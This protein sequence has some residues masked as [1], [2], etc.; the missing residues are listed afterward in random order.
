M[1][2]SAR[3]AI[4]AQLG[5]GERNDS[6]SSEYRIILPPLPTGPT[7]LNTVFLHADV[8]GRPYRVEDFRNTLS[9]LALLPEV[10]TLGAYQMKYVWAVTFRSPEGKRKII[11]AGDLV[12][13][14]RRCVVVDPAN[15]GVRV[16]IHRLLHH[17]PDD[18]ESWGCGSMTRTAV[19]RLKPGIGLE[20]LP[21]QLRI[22]GGPALVVVPG[23]PPLCL[24]CQRT[25][26][27]RRDC[28]VPKCAT[29]HQFGHDGDHCIKTYARATCSSGQDANAER[30]MD[31]ADAQEALKGTGPSTKSPESTG[32]QVGRAASEHPLKVV[33]ASSVHAPTGNREE[34][35]TNKDETATGNKP[36]TSKNEG[37][38]LNTAVPPVNEVH[39]VDASGLAT[40][41]PHPEDSDKQVDGRPTLAEAPGL[42]NAVGSRGPSTGPSYAARSAA[43]AAATT[44]A[45]GR[46]PTETRTATKVLLSVTLPATAPG[47]PTRPQAAGP[48]HGSLL[49]VCG[50]N[51][52]KMNAEKLFNLLCLYGNVVKITKEQKRLC[53]GAD[54][55]PPGQAESKINAKYGVL[56]DLQDDV[57]HYAK[58]VVLDDAEEGLKDGH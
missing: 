58:D 55:G 22:A 50:L 16:K 8:R 19:I 10:L 18:E 17:V 51:P 23:R 6:A 34:A 1:A 32:T 15:R 13:K 9:R 38:Q 14:G 49:I 57:E 36:S 33:A 44:T 45:T 24:R 31:E 20:D 25:E 56:D 52:N 43:P 11:A 41:R 30:V 39:M 40:K 5:R 28:R 12:V 37:P 46:R 53:H 54:G 48:H 7:V 21:H 29:C 42:R 27:I 47:V 26:H 4:V 3:A 35:P 2:G